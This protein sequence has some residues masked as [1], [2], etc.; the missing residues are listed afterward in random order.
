MDTYRIWL[1]KHLQEAT[2]QFKKLQAEDD[3]TGD[4]RDLYEQVHQMWG[5][6]AG[7][8]KCL[9]EFDALTKIPSPRKK[10]AKKKIIS[11]KR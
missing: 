4:N 1:S 3:Q 2:A 9:K 10:P 6:L 5:Y 8:E 7:L 11:K